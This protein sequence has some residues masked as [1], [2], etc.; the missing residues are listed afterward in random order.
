MPPRLDHT[1]LVL[2]CRQYSSDIWW[3]PIFL[4]THTLALRHCCTLSLPVALL[5]FVAMFCLLLHL[6]HNH[7]MVL[8]SPSCRVHLGE[9]L[10]LLVLRGVECGLGFH[11]VILV[12]P[13]S[14]TSS[15]IWASGSYT[16]VFCRNVVVM[17]GV[18]GRVIPV[19]IF[20]ARE[21]GN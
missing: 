1:F 12:L 16:V 6:S 5:A 13:T 20:V 9:I 17:F 8:L 21:G 14:P 15:A 4:P 19:T 3:C 2:P 7:R 10:W 11:S 18:Y